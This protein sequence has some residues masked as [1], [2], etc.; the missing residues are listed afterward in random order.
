[1]PSYRLYCLNG[2]GRISLADWI[3]AETDD[4]AIAKARRLEHGALKCE[5]W[6]GNR[7]I[8]KLD[9]HDLAD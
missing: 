9:S 8:A 7:L 5:V 6:L 2:A 4:D 3:E 1:M